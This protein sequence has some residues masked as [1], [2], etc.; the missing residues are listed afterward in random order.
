MMVLPVMPDTFKL[1]EASLRSV[2]PRSTAD[3]RDRKG[4]LVSVLLPTFNRRRYLAEALASAVRQTYRDLEIFV[5]RDGGEDVGDVVRSFNDPRVVFIDRKENR[6][7]PFSLNEALARARGKYIAYLDDDDVY[8]PNHVEVL[9]NALENETDAQ[10]AYSDLYKTYCDVAPGGGRLALSK[11]VEISRD[12]D[13]FL[14]LYF[15]HVLHVSLMHR[16][17]LLDRTGLYN[18]DLNIL[19]DWDMT[20]RLAFFSDFCHLPA[21]TGEFYSPVGPSDRISF[22]RR[23]DSLEYTRNVL[24]I[25]TTRPPKPW[26]MIEDLSIILL[27]DRLDTHL[28]ETVSRIW[29]HT[30]YPYTLYVPLPLAGISRLNIEMPN[31]VLVPVD[32]LTS[33]AERVDV[34]MQKA[35]GE[36][37]A[38]VPD[39]LTIEERWVE[40]PLYALINSGD[41]EGFLPAGATE[42]CW[43][44]VL[45]RADLQ[46]SRQAHPHLPVDASL[47]AAGIRVRQPKVQELPFQFDELLRQAKLAEADGDWVMAAR[48]FERMAERHQNEL[49]MKTMAARAYLEAGNH[50]VAGRL[51]REVNLKR[52][53]VNTLLLEARVCRQERDFNMAIRL[54]GQAEH[55]LRDCHNVALR[56]A[57][58]FCSM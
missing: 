24:A 56:R 52:P 5:V 29:Q 44:V 8:Y 25:R 54:L 37:I 38:I 12:F 6:G 39:G 15:N 55:W 17:D 50:A 7:K 3:E 34:V 4:P 43:A 49:W 35:D 46:Q 32:S 9:V 28:A 41:R 27:V 10:V 48:L 31:V 33:S 19:I 21:I 22:H 40:D 11:H 30:F 53:T 42:Q 2:A 45:R 18:E 20:R 51:S 58:H 1:S 57:P 23:R 16:R 47:T 14:M 36:Y 26:P 13:R